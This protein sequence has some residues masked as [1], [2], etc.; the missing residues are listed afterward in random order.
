MIES[1]ET[2]LSDDEHRRG[3]IDWARLFRRA[4]PLV[5]RE[6]AWRAIDKLPLIAQR[7]FRHTGEHRRWKMQQLYEREARPRL[8]AP[9]VLF[10]IPGGMHLL[11]HV[12]TAIAAALRLRGYNVHAII[13]DSPYRACVRREAT[14]GMA[15]EDWRS[16]CPRCI[17]SNRD[18]LE[19]MGIPYSSVGDY[20]TMEV[21]EQ[22]R[23]RAEQCSESNILELSHRG[24]LIGRNVLSAVTRYQQGASCSID[25]QILREYAYSALVSAEAAAHV[26]DCFKPDRVLMSHAVYVDWGPALNAAIS[27]GIPVIGWKASYLS[28]RFFFRHVTDPERIDFHAVSDRSWQAR[29]STPLTDEEDADLQTFLDRRYRQRVSFDMR[30][31]QEYTGETDRFR[32]KYRLEKGKP[33]WGI[34]AHINWDSVSDYSPMAYRSFDEWIVDTVEQVSRIPEV[35]WLIKVHPAEVD[36]DPRNGVQR[37]VEA[38]FASLASNVR[39][40]PAGEEISPLEFFDLVDGGVTVYGTSGLELAL[41]GKPVILAGEA[42]YAGRGFTEDGLT[43]ESY[44]RLLARAGTIGR[45]SQRKTALARRYAYSLFMER[46]V[47]LPFVQDP[48][49][50]WWTLQ[51][52]KRDLLIEGKDPF[53][54]FICDRLMDGEDFIMNRHLVEL[55]EANTAA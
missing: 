37:F 5:V 22:L 45:L 4:A 11:L 35:Q 33:V 39:I 53:I 21:R 42:H 23:A 30:N 38:R 25:E 24:L 43:V 32:A 52:E 1:T 8:A 3:S 49:S 34:M 40:I 9:T 13:C 50:P 29:A 48:S 7:R 20:V 36:Y 51:H 26:M 41:A 17:A 15:I 55:A 14:D 6:A 44:R 2:T 31:L 46:Q 12:E 18:V 47:P 27:R 28:A 19:V 16:I 54:D 10:W